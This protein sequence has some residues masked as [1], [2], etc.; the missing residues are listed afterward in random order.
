MCSVW[1]EYGHWATGNREEGTG[2]GGGGPLSY[3]SQS[4]RGISDRVDRQWSPTLHFFD[5]LFILWWWKPR[6]IQSWSIQTYID[7]RGK[8]LL[9]R[10]RV[11]I[12]LTTASCNVPAHT[13]LYFLCSPVLIVHSSECTRMLIYDPISNC[14]YLPNITVNSLRKTMV[15]FSHAPKCPAQWVPLYIPSFY[16]V[17]GFI[18]ISYILHT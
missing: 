18:Y 17:P 15:S 12:M 11:I 14:S 8:N 2:G 13:N 4:Y 9:C 6:D 3:D 16:T 5:F 1:K 10:T 7:S